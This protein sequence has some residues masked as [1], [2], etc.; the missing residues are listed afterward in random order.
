MLQIIQAVSTKLPEFSAVGYY[1][2][3]TLSTAEFSVRL[4]VLQLGFTG[5][6]IN[7]SLV[8]AFM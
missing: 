2:M 8:K 1:S 6:K 5:L 7:S 3:V 4:L